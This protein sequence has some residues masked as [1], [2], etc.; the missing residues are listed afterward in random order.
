MQNPLSQKYPAFDGAGGFDHSSAD[1]ALMSHLAF[2]T[3]KDMPRMDRLF[4]RSALDARQIREARRLS[5]QYHPERGAALP[6]G[7]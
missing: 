7:L 1:A 5:A 6:E 4:R 2:W 3:G